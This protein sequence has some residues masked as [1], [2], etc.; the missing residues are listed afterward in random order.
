[1]KKPDATKMKR[2]PTCGGGALPRWRYL[3]RGDSRWKSPSWFPALYEAIESCN[4]PYHCDHG[5]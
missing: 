5:K 4:D 3:H 1:M 2:C